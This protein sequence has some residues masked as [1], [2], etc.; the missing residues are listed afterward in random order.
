MLILGCGIH[1]LIEYGEDVGWS[2]GIWA[3]YIYKLLFEEGHLLHDKGVIGSILAV[4]FGYTT[5]MELLRFI[6]QVTYLVI[7]LALMIYAY[8]RR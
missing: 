6:F 2:L 8:R 7:G 5:K 1:E 3:I 4:L